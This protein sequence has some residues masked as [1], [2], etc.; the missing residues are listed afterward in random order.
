MVYLTRAI[1]IRLS[2]FLVLIIKLLTEFLIPTACVN[3]YFQEP[4]K[5]LKSSYSSKD[6]DGGYEAALEC[7]SADEALVS[8]SWSF[9]KS[10]FIGHIFSSFFSI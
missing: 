10:Q 2:H 5:K 3:E 7:K 9:D 1:D 4:D 6:I 8:S